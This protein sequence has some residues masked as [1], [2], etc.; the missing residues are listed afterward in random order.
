MGLILSFQRTICLP[1][2]QT[3]GSKWIDLSAPN[4][5]D[6]VLNLLDLNVLSVIDEYGSI[7]AWEPQ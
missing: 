6:N 2:K 1:G 4:H 7:T 5:L 3:S